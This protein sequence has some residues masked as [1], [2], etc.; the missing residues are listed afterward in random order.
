MNVEYVCVCVMNDDFQSLR[1]QL[2]VKFN[3]RPNGKIQFRFAPVVADC[4]LY[5][6]LFTHTHTIRELISR[7]FFYDSSADSITSFVYLFLRNCRLYWTLLD[8]VSFNS[9]IY[10]PISV[11]ID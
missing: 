5:Q 8:R 3:E 1:S 4:K 9:R 10:D 6:C 7:Q 11:K 2:C